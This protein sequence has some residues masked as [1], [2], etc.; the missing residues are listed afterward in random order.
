[1]GIKSNGQDI[2]IVHSHAVV[3]VVQLLSRVQLFATPWS[4]AHWASLSLTISQSLH[5]FTFIASVMPCS[6]LILWCPL[7]LLLS[8][9][10]SIRDFSNEWCVRIRWPKYWNFSFSIS[11]S[12][13]Y[14]GLISLMIDRFGLLAVQGTFRSLLHHHRS[15]ASILCHSAVFTVQLPQPYVTTGKTISL[16]IWNFIGRVM[17]LLFNT[18][19]LSMLSCQEAIVSCYHGCSHH[20]Q[21]CGAQEEEICHCFHTFPFYS[22]CSNGAGCHQLSFFCCLF[23]CLYLSTINFITSSM[24]ISFP[25]FLFSCLF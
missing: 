1:M 5:K 7:F 24:I 21:W 12:S 6:H 17:S 22:P 23:V 10:L 25:C 9:F 4:V 19:C 13:E 11:P 18:L 20:P 2:S 3:V 8:I 16:T 14:S 15:R